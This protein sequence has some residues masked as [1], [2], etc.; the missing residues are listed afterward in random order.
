MMEKRERYRKLPGRRRGIIHGASV[1]LGSDHLLSV[2]SVRFR[3]EYK[4][5]FLRDIQA[6]A[7]AS[8]PRFHIS[9]RSLA[10]AWLFFFAFAIASPFGVRGNYWPAIILG[11]AAALLVGAWLV[12]SA[13]F[14]CRC[15]I[16]TAVS[17]D[18]LPS[19]YRTWTARRF[20]A[21]LEPKIGETQGVIEGP[22]AEAAESRD[23]GPPVALGPAGL[24]IAATASAAGRGRS[25]TT[26]SDIFI[27]TLFASGAAAFL[28]LNSPPKVERLIVVG[29]LILKVIGA[30]GIFI[31]HSRGKLKSAMQKLAI[32]TL[33]VLGGMYYVEQIAAGVVANNAAQKSGGVIAIAPLLSS[34]N[35]TVSEAG[36]ILSVLLGCVGLGIIFTSHDGEAESG[37]A[38]I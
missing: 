5:F 7:F 10:I 6:V 35:R 20:V 30:T 8:A 17:S 26:V 14:S 28:T 21:A 25:H 24:P 4:K 38:P 31:Q 23:I 32:A 11:I 19:V 34:G 9:S 2:K 1:W 15:R 3:E 13:A 33:L 22:W 16:Y 29:F 18:E 12:I 36:G 37:T 27:G